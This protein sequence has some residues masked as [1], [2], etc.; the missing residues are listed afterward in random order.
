DRQPAAVHLLVAEPLDGGLGLLVAAHLDEAEALGAAGVPV[1]DDLG[2][3]HRAELGEQLLQRA[4]G[5]PI[6]QVADVQLLAHGGPPGK[7]P[8]HATA[9]GGRVRTRNRLLYGAGEGWMEVRG[10]PGNRR[11]AQGTGSLYWPAGWKD[12]GNA[13]RSPGRSAVL[14]I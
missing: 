10:R 5:H 6:S 1:H 3:L 7:G 12:R 14:L 9:P 8:R 4:V 13:G 11:E 2:R